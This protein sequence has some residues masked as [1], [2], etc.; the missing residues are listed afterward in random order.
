MH[1][2]RVFAISK[3]QAVATRAIS[4]QKNLSLG[5]STTPPFI[6]QR[7]LFKYSMRVGRVRPEMRDLNF[8]D[9]AVNSA[10]MVMLGAHH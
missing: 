7:E 4:L 6:K 5:E 2:P 9:S 8:W 1:P 10:S 3:V